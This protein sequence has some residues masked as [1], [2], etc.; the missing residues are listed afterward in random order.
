MKK[1]GKKR[2]KFGSAYRTE[3]KGCPFKIS[4]LHR[5]ERLGKSKVSWRNTFSKRREKSHRKSRYAEKIQE[6]WVS[7][8]KKYIHVCVR[9]TKSEDG[10]QY[11]VAIWGE[12]DKGRKIGESNACKVTISYKN[13]LINC[14]E[15]YRKWSARKV[16]IA[17]E[18]IGFCQRSGPEYQC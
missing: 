3:I 10:S 8:K 11:W 16:K 1:G 18:I 4:R 5:K 14:M 15:K 9:N 7:K 12:I 2:R 17:E 6:L 13:K